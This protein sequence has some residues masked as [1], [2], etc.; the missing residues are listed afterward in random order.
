[1]MTPS[2]ASLTALALV[3]LTLGAGVA[4]A[5][6]LIGNPLVLEILPTDSSTLDEASGYLKEIVLDDCD[7]K[8]WKVMVQDT[9]DLVNELE[10]TIPSDDWCQATL[11][12]TGNLHLEGDNGSSYSENVSG[13]FVLPRVETGSF[14]GF[15]LS[16]LGAT[17]ATLEI[18]A[19]G[20]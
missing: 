1:M 13:P 2:R 10:V 5:G 16:D 6:I 18:R 3:A 7:T 19:E 8:T 12:F 9:V 17:N 4:H 15:V 20:Q 11:V 14:N